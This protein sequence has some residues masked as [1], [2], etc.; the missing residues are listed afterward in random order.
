MGR[1]IKRL[2]RT[3]KNKKKKE[4]KKSEQQIIE[5][6]KLA[7]KSFPKS[8]KLANDYV[9]KARNLVMKYKIRLPRELKRRF[10]K[11]CYSY[12][13][14][15]SNLRVRLQGKKVI[16]YCLECKKFMRFPYNKKR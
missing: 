13:V 4:R 1:K 8:K 7:K 12:L 3:K 2:S 9:R 10:C 6:F 15:S 5:Y 16:Y 14:P 11:H